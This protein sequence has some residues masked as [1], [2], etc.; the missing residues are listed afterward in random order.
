MR[1]V[2]RAMFAMLLGVTGA[3]SSSNDNGGGGSGGAGGAGGMGGGTTTP[4]TITAMR[5]D[6]PPYITASD[7]AFAAYTAAHS[8][9]TIKD[10]TLRYPSL[11]STLLA[12][13]K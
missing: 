5:N 1:N 10:T 2:N 6:T 11:T 12:D 3:C 13:L 4:V 9:V 8:N 7:T